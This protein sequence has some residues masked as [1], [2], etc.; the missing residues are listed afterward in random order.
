MPQPMPAALAALATGVVEVPSIATKPPAGRCVPHLVVFTTCRGLPPATVTSLIARVILMVGGSLTDGDRDGPAP[1]L[2]AQGAE[3]AHPG[4]RGEG[5]DRPRGKPQ[6]MLDH[7]LH[8]GS[9]QVVACGG[10]PNGL[11]DGRNVCLEP[12]RW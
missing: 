12:L 6:L 10:Q 2:R 3:E 9:V 5:L 8:T 4:D 11:S 7:F 1:G